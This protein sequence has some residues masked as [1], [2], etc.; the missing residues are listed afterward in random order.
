MYLKST[1][2][3]NLPRSDPISLHTHTHTHTHTPLP[4]HTHKRITPQFA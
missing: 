2:Q 4:Y 3:N 1:C